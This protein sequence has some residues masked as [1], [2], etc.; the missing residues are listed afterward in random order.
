L[1]PARHP[2]RRRPRAAQ[3]KVLRFAFPIAETGFDP[4]QINDLYSSIILTHIFDAPL[5]YDYLARP[6]KV[7]PNTAAELPEVSADY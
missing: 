7:I 1:P 3:E 5:R 4:A 6:V 2:A